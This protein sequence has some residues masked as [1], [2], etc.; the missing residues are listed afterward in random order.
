VEGAGRQGGDAAR[1]V[2]YLPRL[3]FDWLR[4]APDAAAR[5]VDGSMVFVDISGFTALSERLAARGRAGA[6]ILTEVLDTIFSRLL[7]RAWVLGGGL[8]KFG[9]DALLVL[10]EGEEHARRAC[11]AAHDMRAELASAGRIETPAGLVTLRMS[12]GIH[13]GVFDFFLVGDSH[14][15]L[16][17]TGPA[18]SRTVEAEGAAEADQI[19]VSAA[20]AA[21]ID[22]GLL[23]DAV[24]SGRLLTRRPDARE[25][26]TPIGDTSEL[27]TESC[28]PVGLRRQLLSGTDEPEH[29]VVSVAFLHFQ[30]VD[31]LLASRGPLP[32][33][34]AVEEV[35]ATVQRHLDAEGVCFL[36]SDVYGDGGKLILTAGA[37][38]THGNDEERLLRALRR[39]FDDQLPLAIRAGVNRGHVYAGEVGPADRRT[40]TVMGDAVNLAARLMQAAA[41]GQLL[42]SGP[43]LERSET[44]FE[45]SATRPLRVKGKT[46]PVQ[47]YMVEAASGRRR[48]P[49]QRRLPLVGRDS[50]LGRLVAATERVPTGQGQVVQIVGPAG[51]GKTRLIEELEAGHLTRFRQFRISCEQFKS[52][53]AY[54]P[55]MLLLRRLLDIPVEA[56]AEQTGTYLEQYVR[57]ADPGLLPWLPLLANVV[58][59]SVEGTPEVDELEEAFRQGQLER[60]TIGLIDRLMGG[61]ETDDIIGATHRAP[62]SLLFE[63]VYWMDE[64]SRRLLRA[65]GVQ[66]ATR[67]WLLLLTARDTDQSVLPPEDPEHVHLVRLAPLQPEEMEHL[68][69]AAA[70]FTAIPPHEVAALAGRADGNPLFLL[71]LV[72]SG[73]GHGALPDSIEAAIGA[74]LDVL[75]PKDRLALRCAAVLG[76][77]SFPRVLAEEVLP[78]HVPV[79][80]DLGLWERLAEFVEQESH[81]RLRFRHVLFRDVAYEGLSFRRRRDLHAAVVDWVERGSDDRDADAELLALHCLR[82]ERFVDAFRYSRSAG[83][84][85]RRKAATADAAV[86]YRQALD[87]AASATVARDEVSDV[88]EALGDVCEFAGLYAEGAYGYR[89]ARRL[90]D[91]R[92]RV[93]ELLRKEGLLRERAGKYRQA[94]LLYQA[95]I[96]D[97]RVCPPTPE[98]CRV[99]ANLETFLAG[100]LNWQGRYGACVWW[101]RK[102]ARRAEACGAKDVLAHAYYLLDWAYTDLGSPESERYRHLA[103]PIYEELGDHSGMA[104]VLNNLGG[105]AYYEGQWDRALGYYERSRRAREKAGDIV[106][107]ATASSNVAE[108]LCQQGHA[109]RAEHLFR[110]S[111]RVFRGAGWGIGIA[112][113][114]G[115]LG[116]LAARL[117][118]HEEGRRLLIEARESCRAMKLEAYAVEASARLA[119][120][121]L[122]GGDHQGASTLIRSARSEAGARGGLP[123][124]EAMLARLEVHVLAQMGDLDGAERAVDVTLH[125]AEAAD[126][127]YEAALCLDTKARLA[128]STGRREPE[129]ADRAAEL[130]RELGVAAPPRLPLRSSAEDPVEAPVRLVAPR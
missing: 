125:L 60:V 8:V 17:L 40:Y 70:D 85:A 59:A 102:A 101:A 105:N 120:V 6:E 122:L 94:R 57:D 89:L 16:I 129:A 74:R 115:Y 108:I 4:S 14:R 73:P 66:V 77:P 90:V 111:L 98:A 116:L 112:W 88:A 36:G 28:V 56:D 113:V 46:R 93:A 76:G 5:Q 22:D 45:V 110:E 23:G 124:H 100:A 72:A 117:G 79:A 61:M 32:A 27:P 92:V 62:T 52:S 67:P 83:D 118:R 103:L 106:Q 24:G 18:A 78:E 69:L 75:A 53:S 38:R 43:V 96:R 1:L 35:V 86:F 71:E 39:V 97:V 20:T 64:A 19:L 87:A 21:L 107:A 31:R 65:L 41:P 13:S 34:K 58:G 25:G 15:E 47:A 84:T 55:F 42:A 99:H 81:D 68:A 48:E 104:N 123:Y 114:S 82:A 11:A 51:I 2:P 128:S 127:T 3:V 7:A 49:R 109:E 54:W 126:A 63:D 130:F 119:E 12:V 33:A 91:D 50:E 37:P 44:T 121:C 30:G 29:R 26:P 95:G 80:V 10:F 9:G